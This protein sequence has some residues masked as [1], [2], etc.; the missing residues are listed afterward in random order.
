MAAVLDRESGAAPGAHRPVP[1][2]RRPGRAGPRRARRPG[3]RGRA[4]RAGL[5]GPGPLVLARATWPTPSS[6]WPSRPSLAAAEQAGR[7]DAV[8]DELFRFGRIVAGAP[9]LR[10]A[11]ADRVGPGRE[12]RRAV[13][14][15]LGD[16]VADETRRLVRQAV[17]APRG[18]TLRPRAGDLR[19]RWPPTG[20]AGWSP[21]D[22][23]RAAHR[24]AARP[25]RR[26]AAPH[27]RRTS[28]TSTSQLDP[29][30]VGGIRVE[31][32]D[33]VIDGTSSPAS[34]TPADGSSAEP[35]DHD[36]RPARHR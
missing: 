29:D 24:G 12:P 4:G 13:E 34:T 5:G 3:R 26:R 2:R 20:A 15:L 32:G 7:L 16:K 36:S 30:L 23:D 14:D 6:C 18:R 33:E 10:T 22:G 21:R 27:L 35:S 25:A 8:E 9:E 1:H 11:L 31:I 19:R 17:V 28:C